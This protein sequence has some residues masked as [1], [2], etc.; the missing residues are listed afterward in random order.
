[1]DIRSFFKS[2]S[3]LAWIGYTIRQFCYMVMT[4]FF[5]CILPI[6]K[7]KVFFL[8]F[9]G[10]YGDSPKAVAEYLHLHYPE[11]RLE[12]VYSLGS[13]LIAVPD[14]ITP[15]KYETISFFR[16]MATS[17]AW[18][19]SKLL[20]KGTFKRKGQTYIQTWHG[21]KG[22]KKFADDAAREL[23]SYRKRTAGRRFSESEICDWFLT[24]SEWFV[25]LIRSAIGYSGK[26]IKKGV[27]RNDCLINISQDKVTAI[28]SEL[29]IDENKKIVLYAPTFRDHEAS[30]GSVSFNI[31]LG[32]VTEAMKKKTGDDWICLFR[33]H[34]GFQKTVGSNDKE[35]GLLDVSSYP[36]MAELL[37]IADMLITDYSSCAGDFAVKG[38][39]I[40]LYQDDTESF[41]SQDRTLYYKMEE[42][43][44]LVA[45][46]MEEATAL[47][48]GY[49]VKRVVDNCRE[50]CDFYKTCETGDS[51][52]IVS[53]LILSAGT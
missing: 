23:E 11:L 24:G 2:N 39:F 21:D 45:H 28:K 19:C 34:P 4:R 38:G 14:Y 47:I 16:E 41:T 37:M 7:N 27:P 44:F 49:D 48:N 25:P 30:A 26:I 35:T 15:V 20:P 51:C 9:N 32:K 10:K 17:R 50:I 42:S 12:W 5:A 46:N 3:V 29:G 22:F 43:P 1:M 52:R 13:D 36:D 31:D 18:V 6:D 40:L 33:T 8:N 53:D